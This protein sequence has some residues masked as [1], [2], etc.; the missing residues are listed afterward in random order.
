MSSGRFGGQVAAAL[1]ECRRG[2]SASKRTETQRLPHSALKTVSGLLWNKHRLPWWC[3][4]FS[5]AS[6][7]APNPWL[8]RPA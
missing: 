3:F 4:F 1:T 5:G 8:H 6:K 7:L 2:Q